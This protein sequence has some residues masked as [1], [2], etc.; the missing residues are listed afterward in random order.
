MGITTNIYDRLFSILDELTTC[1]AKR[2]YEQAAH[3]PAL[4]PVAVA[5]PLSETHDSQRSGLGVGRE[6]DTC[7]IRVFLGDPNQKLPGQSIQL[8]AEAVID[9]LRPMLLKRTRLENSSGARLDYISQSMYQGYSIAW[10]EINAYID[11]RLL[12]VHVADV[13]L[14]T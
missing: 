3:D 4:A 2:Y 7:I 5:M 1:S 9:E 6:T 11:F 12:I 13:N 14:G 10:R 8:R